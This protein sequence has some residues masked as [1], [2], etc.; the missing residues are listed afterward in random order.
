MIYFKKLL[1][2][3]ILFILA[4]SVSVPASPFDEVSLKK[5]IALKKCERCDLSG[6]KMRDAKLDGAILC[7]TKTPWGID[8]SGC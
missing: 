1:A 3:N 2:I 8:N 5:L 4:I 7:K 6:A